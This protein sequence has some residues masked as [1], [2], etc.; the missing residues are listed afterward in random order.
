[1]SQTKAR[2]KRAAARRAGEREAQER[3][4]WDAVLRAT[5]NIGIAAHIDAGKTTTTERVL[6]Y[7]GR[8][9]RMGEVDDG[10]AHMDWM[11]Q[12]A[13]R[14]ITITS[15]ATTCE[16]RDHRINIIDTPGHVDFTVE[17]ERSLRVLDGSVVIFSGVEGVQP[18]SETVWRQADRYAIPRLAFVN[19]LDRVGADFHRVLH[20]V[21]AHLGAKGLAVQLPIG[22]EGDFVGLVDLVEMRAFRYV[23]DL[24]TTSEDI[25]IP[26]DMQMWCEA[27]R[28]H[29]IVEL[30]EIDEPMAEIYLSDGEPTPAEL[31]A[32]IRRAT[33]G[34][35][36][37]PVL[38]GSALKNKG[39][40][41]LLNAII[42]YL[43]SPLDVG[44]VQGEA[45]DS[46][47]PLSRR[48]DPNDPFCALV[49][50]IATDP[51]VGRLSYVRA[52]AGTLQ[53]G[54][55]VLNVTTGKRERVSRLLRMHA[56]RREELGEIGPGDIVAAVGLNQ[57]TTGDTVC[58]QKHP[59]LLA[60]I[61]FP[62]PV[63]AVA[64]EPK[65]KAD[66]DK[67]SQALGKLDAED[68][69]L[70]VK[71]DEETGQTLI[72]GMGELHLEVI[73]D[74]LLRE[75][76][77][78][79]NV[80]APQVAY[81]ET[82]TQAATAE[83]K[84]IRQTGGRGQYGHVVLHVE[85]IAA[86]DEKFVFED[87]TKGGV[88][89]REFISAIEAGAREALDGGV[90][91]GYPVIH[92]RATLVDGSYHE[93]DSSDVAFRVA[94]SIALRRA[95]EQAEPVL[96]EPIMAVEVITPDDYTGDV[97]S[98]LNSRRANIEGMQPSPGNT[99]TIEAVVP[100]A[101]MFG[102]ATALRSATQGR[103]TYTMEPRRY[104]P[105]PAQVQELI[106]ARATGRRI[107]S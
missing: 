43:P 94:G 72:A 98:D 42:D 67:L 48:P 66:E 89:P 83:G 16:W 101:E 14:G 91:A 22:R 33:V 54:Q 23:D 32:A 20:E 3:E 58:D 47:E 97:T 77:V 18:Q 41:P 26:A 69:T 13:E 40:Q 9:H 61:S 37:V 10:D 35:H 70:S 100:L 73:K 106:V 19:K 86:G 90:L 1:M 64:I 7:T 92:V 87:A 84:Y 65:T 103:G 59:I 11:P 39:V 78:D 85:P 25:E 27:F 51:F 104:E 4:R 8:I 57:T 52:Y 36:V 82:I 24:G 56:N 95:C 46:G 93:V 63:I 88:I 45:P 34:C 44:P 71:V 50:K 62:E 80:G 81:R 38:C 15:A 29:L 99:Q 17:V 21:R 105:V 53:K 75:F 102:Y 30:A 55:S 28:D 31:R 60:S 2:D 76:S 68:P 107:Q 12:E 96:M 6:F 79:A 74:R 5:R 49:F